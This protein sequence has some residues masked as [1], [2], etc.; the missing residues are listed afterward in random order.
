MQFPAKDLEGKS[1]SPADYEGNV[2]LIDFWATWCG[3]CM[4]ELPNVLDAYKKYHE[5]GFEIPAS[6]SIATAT[7]TICRAS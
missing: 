4:A 7:S 5:Q 2:L 3:L 1:V 6:R